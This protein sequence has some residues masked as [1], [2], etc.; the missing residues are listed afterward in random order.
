MA[1]NRPFFQVC[2]KSL[3]RRGQLR[4]ID[5]GSIH[6]L[7]GR[8]LHSLALP[9]TNRV[10]RGLI[11]CR[12]RR[13]IVA[14]A[15][16]DKRV[17][18]FQRVSTSSAACRVNKLYYLKTNIFPPV[19][20]IAAAREYLQ[21]ISFLNSLE[22]KLCNIAFPLSSVWHMKNLKFWPLLISFHTSST[23]HF[24]SSRYFATGHCFR[25]HK[26]DKLMGDIGK[27]KKGSWR[28]VLFQ[29]V[30]GIYVWDFENR[31]GKR[32]VASM[33][34]G[35]GLGL[36]S[37]TKVREIFMILPQVTDFGRFWP[38]FR[39]FFCLMHSCATTWT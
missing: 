9:D 19:F 36:L 8:R 33:R 31:C 26:I 24:K 2:E 34:A 11:L 27:K 29:S 21:P 14:W 7:G 32:F 6:Y 10:G 35:H 4:A 25:F 18:N 12:D 3:G 16:F 5:H 17:D 20:P 28:S 30:C 37:E 38:V 15:V 22:R 23:A 1:K 39:D 13:P